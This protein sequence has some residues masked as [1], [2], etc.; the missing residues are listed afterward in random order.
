MKAAPLWIGSIQATGFVVGH[1]KIPPP[2]DRQVDFKTYV[3][4]LYQFYLN[5]AKPTGLRGA[6]D[7][8]VRLERRAG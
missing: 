1:E 8:A 3:V 2:P 7:F 5:G 6:R 4:D